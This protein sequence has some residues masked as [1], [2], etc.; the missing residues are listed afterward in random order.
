MNKEFLTACNTS[1][2]KPAI[3]Y[4][5]PDTAD[6]IFKDG[7]TLREY[8]ANKKKNPGEQKPAPPKP[9]EGTSAPG[10]TSDLVTNENE[11]LVTD[12]DEK[13]KANI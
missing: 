6:I 11:H 3:F 9:S 1:T 13:L 2:I 8:L 10:A 7:T 12:K 4:C 5:Y